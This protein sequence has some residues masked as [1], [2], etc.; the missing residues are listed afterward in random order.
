MTDYTK[1]ERGYESPTR[2]LIATPLSD[3]PPEAVSWL[4]PGRIPFGK[5]TMLDGDPGLGKSLLTLDLAARVS[6]GRPMPGEMGKHDPAAVI[7]MTAED[8]LADTVRP[9]LDALGADAARVHAIAVDT[10]DADSTQGVTFPMDLAALHD[11]AMELQ[12]RLVVIDPFMAYIGGDVNTRIDHDVR[13]L[14]A[15]MARLAEGTGAAVIVVRHLNKSSMGNALYRGG[16]SIAFIGAARAGLLVARDPD[17]EGRRILATTKMNLAPEPPS[18]AF[19]INGEQGAPRVSWLGESAHRA[20]DLVTLVEDRQ[21]AGDLKAFLRELVEVTPRT[22]P[23][24]K[25]ECRKAG[26]EV[27]DRTLR[28]ARQAAG[29]TA[30]RQGFGP[31]SVM[32]WSLGNG[33]SGH[34]PVIADTSRDMSGMAAMGRYEDPDE[35]ARAALREGA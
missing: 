32:V 13:R 26:F 31:G 17:D 1:I 12:A 2:R 9:R 16:G 10:G 34:I 30:A 7:I 35:A 14:L 28:R 27:A 23:E 22:Y 5:L 11:K 6:T 24:V 8:G 21:E 29:I 4:W 33:H 25:V 18:L 3:V 19:T 15:P 20:N